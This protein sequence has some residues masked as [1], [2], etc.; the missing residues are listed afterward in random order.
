MTDQKA[1]EELR[2]AFKELL[3]KI[4]EVQ[5]LLNQPT[6]AKEDKHLDQRGE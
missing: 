2:D 6:P 4:H 5:Q 3:L 1:I